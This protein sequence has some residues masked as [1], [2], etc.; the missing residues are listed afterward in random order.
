ML[1]ATSASFPHS[2]LLNGTNNDNYVDAMSQQQQATQARHV[3][4][5]KQLQVVKVQLH[6]MMSQCQ[7]QDRQSVAEQALATAKT[8]AQTA[9]G[10]KDTELVAASLQQL[11]R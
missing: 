2:A 8:A 6:C 7:L 1:A 4:H 5:A 9:S 3:Q 11:S 10:F